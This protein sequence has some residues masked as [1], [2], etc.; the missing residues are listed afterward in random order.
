MIAEG[1]PSDTFSGKL[2]SV[3][4]LI[5]DFDSLFDEPLSS[6]SRFDEVLPEKC[7]RFPP[8]PAAAA[9][10]PSPHHHLPPRRA[11]PPPS[12]PPPAA[13]APPPSSSSYIE[14]KRKV[15]F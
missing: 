7:P 9:A 15:G 13:A 8:P 6:P 14:L 1:T 5:V 12:P 3:D 2:L 11:A 4:E 10:L